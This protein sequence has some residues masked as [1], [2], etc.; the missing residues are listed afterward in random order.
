MRVL[1]VTGGH[2]VDLDAFTDMLAG[3]CAERGW[4]FA[5]AVQPA[6]QDWLGPEH[7][8]VF[9]AVLCYDLPGLVLRRGTAPQP[10]PPAPEVTRRLAEL[11]HAGQGFVFLHHA[12]AG[13]PAWPGWAEVLGGRYHYAPASLR[14][15]RW[16]DSGFRY[17][18]YT[19][20]VLAA[21]HPVC[22]GV[23]DFALDDELYC[24]PVF[25]AD[26][27]PLLRA[28]AVD[29]PFRETYHEV[30]GTPRSGPA[31]EHPPAS[32]LIGWA[33][34]AGRSPV[35]YLQPGDGPDTFGHPAYRRLVANALEWVS[36]PSARDWAARHPTPLVS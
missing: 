1:A 19:A 20:R 21:D 3:I 25:D 4:V 33:K 10:V 18:R 22:A 24:C 36:S 9:D 27:V 11:F 31:W 34:T 17:A 23:G 8:G 14:G 15:L 29:G 16:P 13:W 35:V 5:H 6:A 2:R 30:L 7:L 28:D 12:L 26:V 32:D